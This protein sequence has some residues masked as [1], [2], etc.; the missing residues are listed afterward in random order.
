MRKIEKEELKLVKIE[1]IKTNI[2]T[3]QST[4]FDFLK[5]KVLKNK[6]AIFFKKNQSI[7]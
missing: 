1:R 4:S 6:I 7:F 5:N 2:I 3:L